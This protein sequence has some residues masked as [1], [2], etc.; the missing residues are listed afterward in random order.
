MRTSLVVIILLSLALTYAQPEEPEPQF[1]IQYDID[2]NNKGVYRFVNPTKKLIG[3]L[4][5]G[6]GYNLA[7]L[8]Q[9]MTITVWYYKPNS[10]RHECGELPEKYQK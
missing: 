3:C 2:P 10:M 1:Q 6:D 5:R 7:I 8:V 9:P 4:V